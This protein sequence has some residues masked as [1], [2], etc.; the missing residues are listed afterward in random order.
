MNQRFKVIILGVSFLVFSCKK[1]LQEKDVNDAL[2]KKVVSDNAALLTHFGDTF[3]Q[4][5]IW[6]GFVNKVFDGDLKVKDLKKRGD[7]GLGS[8][9]FLDGELVMLDGIPY[10]VRENGEITIG[11]DDDEVVYADAAFFSKKEVFSIT[12]NIHFQDLPLLLDKKKRTPHYF[13]IYKIHGS[14]K[15]IKLGGLPRVERPF[16]EG[17]DVLIPRRPVF[18]AENISGTLVGFYCP[19]YIGH[20]NAKGHHFHFISDDK[21]L[22][23][24]VMGFES[25]NTLEVQVDVKTKYQFDLPVSEDFETVDLTKEFQY[26]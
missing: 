3:Y 19:D 4:Y 15:H 10:R 12:H 21:K 2:D 26:N 18:E 24:H 17:L 25:S 7:V 23:G 22:G 1:S 6:F 13:Y 8:F 20:I 5:S 11:Q 9:D 16:N 14:F